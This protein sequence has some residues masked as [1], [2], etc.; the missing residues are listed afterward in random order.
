MRFQTLL[1][2][3]FSHRPR[4]IGAYD[5]LVRRS[6][7]APIAMPVILLALLAAVH[8]LAASQHEPRSVAQAHR[9]EANRG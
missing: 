7:L 5:T 6:I 8:T 1:L 9:A 4:P 3:P 2:S